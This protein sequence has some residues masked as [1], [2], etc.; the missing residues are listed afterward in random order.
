MYLKSFK[1]YYLGDKKVYI[2]D[3][4]YWSQNIKKCRGS[5]PEPV[6]NRF[7]EPWPRPD[8][9]EPENS[10]KLSRQGGPAFGLD[11]S[12]PYVWCIGS[13]SGYKRQ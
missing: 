1:L 7:V 6:R 3:S 11:E 13:H 8:F 4:V 10:P 2:F 12:S 5:I 9:P